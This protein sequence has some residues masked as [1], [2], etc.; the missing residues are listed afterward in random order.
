MFQA[1]CCSAPHRDN[2]NYY[3]ITETV[4]LS[5][6]HPPCSPPDRMLNQLSVRGLFAILESH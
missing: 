1:A 5:D 2:H 4:F 3:S 6:T